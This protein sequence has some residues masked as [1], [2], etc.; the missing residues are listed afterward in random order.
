VARAESSN[1]VG[2]WTDHP[3]DLFKNFRR[4]QSPRKRRSKALEWADGAAAAKV[5]EPF[6]KT[7]G[8]V[9]LL[10][11]T[12]RRSDPTTRTLPKKSDSAKTFTAF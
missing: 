12:D 8:V 2:F 1:S 6:W 7:T 4:P 3:E 9:R 5:A 10:A 11:K